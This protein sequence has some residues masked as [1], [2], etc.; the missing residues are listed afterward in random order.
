MN[1]RHSRRNS[2]ARTVETT[3]KTVDEAIQAAV[4]RL[5]TR[6]E[7]IEVDVLDEGRGGFLGIGARE[8]RIR[9]RVKAE[10]DPIGLRPSSRP[11]SEVGRGGPPERRMRGQGGDRSGGSRVDAPR[12]GRPQE[13]PQ[14]TLE[15]GSRRSDQPADRREGGP[16]E[17]RSTRAEGSSAASSD[18]RVDRRSGRRTPAKGDERPRGRGPGRRED[19]PRD[20]VLTP[21]ASNQR[22]DLLV[23]VPSRLIA[24]EQS[25]SAP[26]IEG[27]IAEFARGLFARM[28]FQVEVEVHFVDGA[29]EVRAA[30]GENDAIL[31][32]RK[33]ET[34]EALQ[35]ILAKMA[36]RGREDL[37]RVRVDVSNYR[38]QRDGELSE[39]ALEM[40]RQVKTSGAEMVTE[41]L[42][43]A[44]RRI[45]HR[46]LAEDPSV[47]THALGDGMIKRIWIGPADKPVPEDLPQEPRPPIRPSSPEVWARTRDDSV[48]EPTRPERPVHPESRAQGDAAGIT[49]SWMDAGSKADTAPAPEWGRR[50]KPAKGR[51]R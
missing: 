11:R 7:N 17:F 38:A 45:I 3:G 47:K 36:S 51:R 35:H 48:D 9:A 2:P 1:E 23:R 27:E 44:E 31:I 21:A 49:E 24:V 37:V 22:A 19:R 5:R 26:R 46:T 42:P 50:P 20:G 15:S 39:R 8:A 18:I 29:Y 4:Q 14:R 25:E 6:R 10:R 32:G 34:L 43:A 33:G 16:A 12:G 40:A 30:G 28:G 41:P 13:S